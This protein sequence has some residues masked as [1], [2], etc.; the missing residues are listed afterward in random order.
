[1]Q[2][3]CI[4]LYGTKISDEDGHIG[5]HNF[6][7]I[8]WVSNAVRMRY[9][10][11]KKTL[12][13]DILRSEHIP[14]NFFTPFYEQK[15]L[16]CKVLNTYMHDT[17]KT[18]DN[19]I[20]EYPPAS[21]N[22][23]KDRTSYDVFIE[24]RHT[25]LSKGIIGIEVKYTEGDYPIGER[26]QREVKD[27]NSIYWIVTKLS[28]LYKPECYPE[29]L[30]DSILVTDR[31]RQVWRNQLLGESF[32]QVPN[33]QWKHSTLIMLYPEGN[34]HIGEVTKG[35]QDILLPNDGL[36]FIPITYQS[37]LQQIE[38]ENTYPEGGYRNED[39]YL[40]HGWCER[41]YIHD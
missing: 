33:T 25:D 4:D 29:N 30:A 20:I 37:F 41:R 38:K 31:Y 14:F 1:M 27:P 2:V 36:K 15:E 23:L 5:M 22:P 21:Q 11:Q 35:Y 10:N 40:W 24:Y 19:I 39:I 7:P 3:N 32:L 6:Y 8:K 26:E 9:P 13:C 34:I 17:V 16:L 18:I 28:G 12:Y